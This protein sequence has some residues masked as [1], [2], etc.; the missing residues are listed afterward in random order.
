MSFLARQRLPSMLRILVAVY[1]P[2]YLLLNIVAFIGYYYVYYALISYQNY[3]LFLNNI[4][5]GLLYSLVLTSSI[6]ITIAV[7]SIRNTRNNKAR[8]TGTTAGT[9]VT[10]L[11]GVIGGCGCEAPLV[12]NLAVIGLSASEVVSLNNFLTGYQI[13]IFEV[14]IIVNV[15]VVIYYLYRLSSPSCKISKAPQG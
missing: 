5:Y 13:Q 11:A 6:L 10:L 7:Y 3:G 15:A 8:T 1:K 14:M 4:P 12:L 9:A 2:K